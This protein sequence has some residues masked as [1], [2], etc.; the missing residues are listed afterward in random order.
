MQDAINCRELLASAPYIHSRRVWYIEHGKNIHLL[1]SLPISSG[2]PSF[3]DP[4][5]G[6]GIFEKLGLMFLH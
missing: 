5:P 1:H 2:S 6:I 3:L 4:H